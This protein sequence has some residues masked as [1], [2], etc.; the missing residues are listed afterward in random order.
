M[1][2]CVI[3]TLPD[4]MLPQRGIDPSRVQAPQIKSGAPL[5]D[6]CAAEAGPLRTRSCTDDSLCCHCGGWRRASMNQPPEGFSV[7]M[8][9]SD[10]TPSR[11]QSLQRLNHYSD[12]SFAPADPEDKL[13]RPRPS[14]C[15]MASVTQPQD[16]C[17]HGKHH[18]CRT[19][20]T[21]PP[22]ARSRPPFIH[23]LSSA[24]RTERLEKH[25]EIPLGVVPGE[26]LHGNRLE[27]KER[28]D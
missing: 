25:S 2:V 18:L 3:K 13:P 28:T 20:S 23:F 5:L 16:A 24:R 6:R 27:R 17:S 11:A 1:R 21:P 8:G 26:R 15:Q 19:S 22:I 9:C 4:K 14:C 10:T 12:I 7:I